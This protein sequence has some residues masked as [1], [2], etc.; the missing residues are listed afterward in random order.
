MCV[1]FVSRLCVPSVVRRRCV[2]LEKDGF[3]RLSRTAEQLESITRDIV[4]KVPRVD[5]AAEENAATRLLSREGF[6]EDVLA[7]GV[8]D[9]E[10]R[11]TFEDVFPLDRSSVDSYLKSVHETLLLVCIHCT[12]SANPQCP[13]FFVM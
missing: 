12:P 9:V 13:V 7:R 4:R 6:D 1:S 11:L 2:Q 8:R 3:P 5:R 10:L